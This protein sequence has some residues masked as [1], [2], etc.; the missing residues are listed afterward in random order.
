MS[1]NRIPFFHAMWCAASVATTSTG[2]CDCRR[3]KMGC[4]DALL[5]KIESDSGGGSG[6]GEYCF[7]DG[8]SDNVVAAAAVVAEGVGVGGF[9]GTGRWFDGAGGGIVACVA[10]TGGGGGGNGR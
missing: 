8:R 4:V 1:V 7:R 9:V 6:G 3:A 2:M 10:T 5:S